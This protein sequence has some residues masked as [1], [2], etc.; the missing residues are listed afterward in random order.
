MWISL[1]GNGNNGE[2]NGGLGVNPHTDALVIS[3]YTSDD[4][5]GVLNNDRNPNLYLRTNDI[6]VIFFDPSDG[7]R[8]TKFYGTPQDD[9]A[10]DLRVD[11]HGNIYVTGWTNGRFFYQPSSGG[12]DNLLFKLNDNGD[13][14]WAKQWGKGEEDYGLFLELDPTG[15][16]IWVAGVW[17]SGP[18]MPKG[19]PFDYWRPY[20]P[21]GVLNAKTLTMFNMMVCFFP[22]QGRQA[23]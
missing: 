11:L 9:V 14:L 2:W 10:N 20:P 23:L 7:H 17:N 12:Y 1:F 5:D 22:N 13:I 21:Q 15:N 19:K 18:R 3:G 4:L 16:N 6:Y 8:L